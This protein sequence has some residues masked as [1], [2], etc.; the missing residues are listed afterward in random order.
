MHD[1][2]IMLDQA[3]LFVDWTGL[4]ITK[5]PVYKIWRHVNVF[6]QEILNS[7]SIYRHKIWE[8]KESVSTRARWDRPK[9]IKLPPVKPANVGIVML[10]KDIFDVIASYPIIIHQI[11]AQIPVVTNLNLHAD[12]LDLHVTE[13]KKLFKYSSACLG[14][15]IICTQ[16]CIVNAFNLMYLFIIW[17]CEIKSSMNKDRR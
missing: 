9:H 17:V 10:I 16:H 14:C 7:H 12:M 5:Y 15:N 8:S 13:L 6:C 2:I 1:D 4:F 3:I 11:N